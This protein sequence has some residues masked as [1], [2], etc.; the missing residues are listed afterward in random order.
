MVDIREQC[1]CR[2]QCPNF[3]KCR[4]CIASHA[5]FYTVPKCIK[6]MQQEMKEK[7][8]HPSNPHIRKPLAERVKEFYE[9]NPDSHLRTAAE[10][11]RITEWQLLDAMEDTVPVPVEEFSSVYAE[12]Q[13]L[14]SVMLHIDVNGVLM[15]LTM[16][17]P[18]SMDRNGVKIIAKTDGEMSITSLIFEKEIYALFLVKET[19][20]G[21]KESMSLAI[22]GED[23]KIMLSIYLRRGKDGTIEPKTRE[24]FDALWEKYKK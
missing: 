22:V 14:E 8:L 9:Q 17:L 7:H 21:G 11:L 20:C 1:P 16:P 3:G 4:E 10:E 19:L 13:K 18:M 23:E 12:L 5:S 15:Q 24:V 2:P 6:M